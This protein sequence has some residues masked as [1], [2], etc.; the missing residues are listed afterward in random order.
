MRVQIHTTTGLIHLHDVDEVEL[1]L[2]GGQL[3]VRHR[4]GRLETVP[5]ATCIDVVVTAGATP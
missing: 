5:L 1:D 3:R 2:R 4:D